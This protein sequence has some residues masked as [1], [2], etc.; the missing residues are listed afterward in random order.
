MSKKSVLGLLI[1]MNFL[2]L[3]GQLWPEEAPSFTHPV[4]I[5]FLIFSLLFFL[6]QFS[7]TKGK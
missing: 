2:V 3:A 5:A 7:R 6:G 1:L 4:T